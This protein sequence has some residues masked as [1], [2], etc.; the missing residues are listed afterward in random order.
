MNVTDVRVELV[1]G[2]ALPMAK[3]LSSSIASGLIEN[4]FTTSVESSIA[5][6]FVLKGIAEANWEDKRVP[7]V[8]LIHWTLY[9]RSGKSIGKYTQGVRGAR[10]KWEYGDPKI[11]KAVGK[12]AAKSLAS[13]IAKEE[14]NPVKNPLLGVRVLVKSVTGAPGDGNLALRNAIISE[15]RGSDVYVIEDNKQASLTLTGHVSLQP[16]GYALEEVIVTWR[17][18]TVDGF[19]VGRATQ[20]NTITT[21]KLDGLWG[22]E[23]KKIAE[24]ALIGIQRIIGLKTTKVSAVKNIIGEPKLTPD[25]EENPDRTTPPLQ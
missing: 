11:I 16:K 25:L 7:F 15:L 18:Q 19:E 10:W 3:L 24:A 8:M 22:V 1:Q 14:N 21:G 12:G 13:M 4:G 5:S 23:A 9:D 20:E 17:V 6:R 2:P